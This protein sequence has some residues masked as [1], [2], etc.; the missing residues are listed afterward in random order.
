MSQ[1]EFTIEAETLAARCRGSRIAACSQRTNRTEFAQLV[2][3]EGVFAALW[4]LVDTGLLGYMAP[5]LYVDRVLSRAVFTGK[6][7]W[8]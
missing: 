3:G 7:F 2:V 1:L 6:M 8:P 5:E 4:L